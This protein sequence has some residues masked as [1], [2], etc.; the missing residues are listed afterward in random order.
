M[1]IY[2][3]DVEKKYG[4]FQFRLYPQGEPPANFHHAPD[5]KGL[6]ESL[7]KALEP[8]DTKSRTDSVVF[9]HIEYATKTELKETVRLSKY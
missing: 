7:T 1:A 4:Q 6:L 3:L 5:L 9:R 2:K 8:L